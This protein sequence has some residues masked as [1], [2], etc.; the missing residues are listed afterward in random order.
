MTTILMHI[1]HDAAHEKRLEA[2][3]S[4][5]RACSAHLHCVH[6]TP[7]EAYVGFERLGGVLVMND[8]MEAIQGQDEEI[9]R[10]L[11]AKLSGEDVTWDFVRVTGHIA[12][13]LVRRS[14]LVDLIVTGREPNSDSPVPTTLP[15]LGEL[16]FRAR[17]PLYVPM[18]GPQPV[19]PT[20][21]A[22]IAWDGSGEAADT[23]RQAM[24]FLKRA[25]SVEVLTATEEGKEHRFPGT[26]LMKYLS[27]HGIHAN[28]QTF[29]VAREEIGPV[30]SEIALE[31]DAS[32]LLMGGY[33]H[34]R[35][36]E[37]LFGGVTRAL[38]T[39]SPVP[40]IIGR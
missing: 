17:T 34:S 36:G 27:R 23:V 5:A 22:V 9:K 39:D 19:H 38:L 11:E 25:E 14:A 7:I 33:N 30:L 4:L 8:V 29:E 16:L 15:H 40:L 24:A 20:A 26:Q 12:P 21:K 31:L 10:S 1:Q 3:L 6:V 2:A 28:L 35:L 37:Y 18:T 32:Y 13:E